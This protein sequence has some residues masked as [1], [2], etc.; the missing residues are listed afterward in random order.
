M[1]LPSFSGEYL[2]EC[3]THLPSHVHFVFVIRVFMCDVGL[4]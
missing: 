1:Q 4:Y 3:D 2:I